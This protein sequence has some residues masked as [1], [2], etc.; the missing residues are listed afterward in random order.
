MLNL[1]GKD[2][3]KRKEGSNPDAAYDVTLL[4][5]LLQTVSRRLRWLSV[6]GD[7]GVARGAMLPQ[8]FSISNNFVL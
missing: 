6:I 1:V 2:A 3:C 7:I 8:I 5:N 4:Q